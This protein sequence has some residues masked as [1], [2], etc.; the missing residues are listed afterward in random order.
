MSLFV[1]DKNIH[2]YLRFLAIIAGF[3]LMYEG[4]RCKNQLVVFIGFTTVLVD[5]FTFY[6][7]LKKI[8]II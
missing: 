1:I 6:I 7:S 2:V 3:I 8:K 5:S 4:S